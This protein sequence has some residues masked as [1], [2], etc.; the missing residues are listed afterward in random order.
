MYFNLASE[1]YFVR[2]NESSVIYNLLTGEAMHLDQ[3]ETAVMQRIHEGKECEQNGFVAELAGGGWGFFSENRYFIDK[4]RPYT[5][6]MLLRPDLNPPELN[7]VFLQLTDKCGSSHEFCRKMFCTPCRTGTGDAHELSLDHCREI[8]RHLSES[9]AKN[10]I[11]TGGDLTSY[12]MLEAV[13]GHVISNG[14]RCSILVNSEGDFTK[15]L[16]HTVPIMAYICNADKADELILAMSGQKNVTMICP[17]TLGAEIRNKIKQFNFSISSINVHN[18][19]I[20]AQNLKPCHMDDFFN[21]KDHNACLNGRMFIDAQGNL[22]PCFQDPDTPIGNVMK[23]DFPTLYRKL[24]TNYWKRKECRPKCAAC[25]W[26]YAC[27]VC[28]YMNPE[29]VCSVHATSSL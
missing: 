23:D 22:V 29:T 15:P 4:L 6:Y 19:A 16:P 8:I 10:I 26:F 18:P 17:N 24:I 3:A 7:V 1:C 11:L 5:N 14:I 28:M 20:T 12:E 9:G 25:E 27:P 13:V 2:G 21:K